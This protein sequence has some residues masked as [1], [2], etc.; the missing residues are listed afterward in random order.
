MRSVNDSWFYNDCYH[1]D[2]ISKVTTPSSCIN[3]KQLQAFVLD[4]EN[5]LSKESV[6]CV[7][8][9]LLKQV[10]P[11]GIELDLTHIKQM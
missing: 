1:E 6:S 10:L 5:L 2:S 9:H 7:S 11:L 3:L 8:G 4:L